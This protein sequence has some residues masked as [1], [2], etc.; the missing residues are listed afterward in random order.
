MNT[1]F[2]CLSQDISKHLIYCTILDCWHRYC[3]PY[4]WWNG[5]ECLFSSFIA[6]T[7]SSLTNWLP[8]NVIGHECWECY[9]GTFTVKSQ[10]AQPQY[11]LACKWECYILGLWWRAPQKPDC[12]LPHNGATLKQKKT[13]CGWK[14][15]S[16]SL[17]QSASQ[18]SLVF[19]FLK[20]SIFCIHRV[21]DGCSV[22]LPWI[23]H[24]V[25]HASNCKVL[26]LAFCSP[27]V[28]SIPSGSLPL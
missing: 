4:L 12:A 15:S 25:T 28:M 3:P 1:I 18:S 22:L 10:C 21:F 11:F 16:K 7:L 23:L 2:I 13:T 17:S 6:C 9:R 24:E 20:N 5:V 27:F 14:L 19:G 8:P 26:W